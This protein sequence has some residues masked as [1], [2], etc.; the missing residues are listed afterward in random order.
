[1][2]VILLNMFFKGAISGDY[3]TNRF[4]LRYDT[5]ICIWIERVFQGRYVW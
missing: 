5:Q 4:P 2:A 3:R 1:M